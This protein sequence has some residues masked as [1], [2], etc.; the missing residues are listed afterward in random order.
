[1]N[2]LLVG[3]GSV[4]KRHF[5]LLKTFADHIAIVEPLNLDLYEKNL[6]INIFKSLEEFLMSIDEQNR[7]HWLSALVVIANWGPDHFMIYEKLKNFGFNNF[8]IEKPIVSK[9]C[10]LEIIAGDIDTKN[11][12]VWSNFHLRYD[13]GISN[14][15]KF[16][17]ENNLGKIELFSVVGGAKCIS[18]NGIHWLDLFFELN[19]Y[20]PEIYFADAINDLKNPRNEN[21]AFLSGC[22]YVRCTN[23]SKF[24]L[25]F[26]NESYSD[27]SIEIFWS[28]HR[29]EIS[30]GKISIF[31]NDMDRTLPFNRTNYFTK[32]IFE[33]SLKGDGMLNLYSELLNS[34]ESMNQVL[35]ANFTI[36]KSLHNMGINSNPSKFTTSISNDFDW[37]IS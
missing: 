4:G 17:F 9:L 35:K 28:N 8:L 19:P 37:R 11:I 32:L 6:N 3:H 23:N 7:K 14:L 27:A 26:T 20:E 13:S 1:M 24:S 25:C 22:L 2:S 29:C 12:K 5:E 15:Q 18:T 31:E 30:S 34:S 21:L 33:D 16:A 10:E 36:L